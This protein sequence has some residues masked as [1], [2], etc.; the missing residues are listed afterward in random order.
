MVFTLRLVNCRWF[1]FQSFKLL[2][3]D[4]S[5]PEVSKIRQG[6]SF[7]RM[8]KH[9]FP[10]FPVI[11]E[12]THTPDHMDGIITQ[13]RKI[14]AGF[15]FLTV[16]KY[17]FP[18]DLGSIP[19]SGRFPWRRKWQPTPVFLP[20]ESHGRRN[21]MGYSPRGRKELDRTEWLH[22]H[23][24][25]RMQVG[26]FPKGIAVIKNDLLHRWDKF[27]RNLNLTMPPI[28]KIL[29]DFSVAPR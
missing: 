14:H 15:A 3:G 18:G 28:A 25:N 23:F 24:H 4:Q 13:S 22:F 7:A 19:G 16:G 29:K 10:L 2:L 6:F 21:L 26:G 17:L 5:C 27:F 1:L 20:G 12:T 8:L 11:R 9:L